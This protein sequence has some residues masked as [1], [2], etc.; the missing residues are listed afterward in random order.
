MLGDGDVEPIPSE[1]Q[2]AGGAARLERGGRDY[3]PAGIVEV[4]PAGVRTDVVGAAGRASGLQV[5]P[6]RAKVDRYDLGVTVSPLTAHES[7]A[8]RRAQIDDRL[9]PPSRWR[10]AGGLCGRRCGAGRHQEQPGE[11]AP[12]RWAPV[13]PFA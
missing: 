11:G 3:G 12:W 4:R 10:L 9:G 7:H 8:L 5:G 6:R 1:R 13:V 2:P